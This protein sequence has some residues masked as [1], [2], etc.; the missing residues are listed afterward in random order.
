MLLRDVPSDELA[1]VLGRTTAGWLAL[2]MVLKAVGLS[3]HE[4][5]LWHL[6]PRPRPSLGSVYSLGLA[7]GVL[8]LFLPGRG[9]DVAAVVFLHRELRVP[10]ATATAAVGLTGFLE[11]AVFATV[12]AGV[13][14]VDLA[15]WEVLLGVAATGDA[16]GWAGGLA[17]LALLAT[18]VVAVVGRRLARR[19]GS[20]QRKGPVGLVVDIVQAAGTALTTPSM[21]LV[22]A[23]LCLIQVVLMVAA[24]AVLLPALQVDIQTPWL[25]AAGV[26]ALSSLASVVLPPSYGA[27]P[28]AASVAVLSLFGVARTEA[29][30]F[31][32][33]WWLVAHGPAVGLGLPALW[34]RPGW[35]GDDVRP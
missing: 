27:G 30:A 20:D 12:V 5:R 8:N 35:R 15:R 16:L 18:A 7:A 2:G 13:L 19:S 21:L 9:G 3:L 10:L 6:L 34:G 33:L 22:N 1:L 31:T 26:L 17:L 11:A 14:V 23:L 29:L 4:L 32:A 28:A 24:F 25:A